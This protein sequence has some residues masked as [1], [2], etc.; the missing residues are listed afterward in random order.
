MGLADVTSIPRQTVRRRLE[1]MQRLGWVRQTA[2]H[3]W[4]IARRPDSVPRI[5]DDPFGIDEVLADL[6]KLLI[7]FADHP[8][9][10]ARREGGAMSVEER[11]EK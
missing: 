2:D 4:H 8:A 1:A 3:R 9:S 6:G 5:K 7:R 11:H 10:D